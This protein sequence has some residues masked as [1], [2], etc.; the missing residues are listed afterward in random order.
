MSFLST[1]NNASINGWKSASADEIYVP[2]NSMQQVPTGSNQRFGYAIALSG[3]GTRC[4]V[5][6]W[7]SVSGTNNSYL[8]VFIKNV[9]GTW[10]QEATLISAEIQSSGRPLEINYDGSIIITGTATGG[11]SVKIYSRTGT[12]WTLTQTIA[13]ANRSLAISDDG[14]IIVIGDSSYNSSRG[15]VYV[16]K[17]TG[18]TWT[19]YSTLLPSLTMRVGANFGYGVAISG[20]KQYIAVSCPGYSVT[21]NT[22]RIFIF[23]N[24][25]EQAIIS[26]SS[27]SAAGWGIALDATGTYVSFTFRSSGSQNRVFVYTRSG[28]TWT[29]QA[30]LYGDSANTENFA[31]NMAMDS[32]ANTIAV[33]ASEAD[34]S[35]TVDAGRIYIFK[36][37]GT[38]W[39][40]SQ[41]LYTTPIQTLAMQGSEFDGTSISGD[42]NTIAFGA[43]GMDISPYTKAGKVF[44]YNLT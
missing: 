9:D 39:Y 37:I 4:A 38:G 14:E 20:D 33:M 28:S 32:E 17:K 19:I 21:P 18:S 36:R 40:N 6:T 15:I 29:L 1:F 30:Q 23:E 25:I 43:L 7:Y 31:R 22:S 13:Q 10:S 41:S 24:Y 27:D 42:G 26:P 2:G 34:V 44:T 11:A 8:Y 3:D 16:Y 12:A 35:G 5:R